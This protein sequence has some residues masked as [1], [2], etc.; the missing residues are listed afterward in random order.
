[1]AAFALVF[2]RLELGFNQTFNLDRLAWFNI[3]VS[4][5]RENLYLLPRLSPLAVQYI[6]VLTASSIWYSFLLTVSTQ[7]RS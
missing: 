4:Q 3:L 1:M 5:P 2:L 7:V 6:F